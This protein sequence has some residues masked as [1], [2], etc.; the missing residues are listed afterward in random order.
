MSD[1]TQS[2]AAP[3]QPATH[4]ENAVCSSTVDGEGKNQPKKHGVWYFLWSSVWSWE[5]HDGPRLSAALAFYALLALA[6]LALM[7]V[8]VAGM[9]LGRSTAQGKIVAEASGVIGP[10]AT[11]ALQAVLAHARKPSSGIVGSAV[12][13]CVLLIGASRV[14]MELREALNKIWD[15]RPQGSFSWLSVIKERLLSFLMVLVVGFLLVILLLLSMALSVLEKW[16]SE[17]LAMPDVALRGIS[18]AISFASVVV[19]IA[20]TFRYVPDKKLSWRRVWW[21]SVLTGFLFTIGKQL[22]GLYL[23]KAAPGSPYGAAGAVVV[24]ILWVYYS[25]M[26]FYLG[27][28]MTRMLSLQR[29]RPPPRTVSSDRV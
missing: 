12:G 22:I 27:A 3:A 14:F 13:L 7:I 23:G 6:P 18:F 29:S 10:E 8:S 2:S 24:L 1:R 5:E 9:I 21:G 16:H 26:S 4:A 28:E 25:S 19:L 11:I 20:L 15:I 17:L